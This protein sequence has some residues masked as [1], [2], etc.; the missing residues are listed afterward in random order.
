MSRIAKKPVVIPHGVIL[1]IN[2]AMVSVKGPK[3]EVKKSVDKRVI[4]KK[5]DRVVS[6][7]SRNNVEG[8]SAASGAVRAT[9]SNMVIGV[10]EGFIKRLLLVGVGFKAQVQGR[11]LNLLLGFS[12]P[13]QYGIPEGIVIETPSQTEII[14]KGADKSVVGQVAAEIKAFRLPEPYKGKGIRYEGEVIAMKEGKKK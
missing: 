5:E 7:I 1:D 3:G 11:I 4:L 6:F 12:H 9:V 8:A 13:V 14:V 2:G 10:T